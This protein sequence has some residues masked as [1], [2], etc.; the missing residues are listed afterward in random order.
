[1]IASR[2]IKMLEKLID[3]HGDL[4]VYADDMEVVQEV[5]N[6]KYYPC[7]LDDGEPEMFYIK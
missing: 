7:D 1:M 5:S 3:E 4:A 6:I 2:L